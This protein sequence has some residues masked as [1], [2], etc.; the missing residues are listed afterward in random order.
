MALVEQYNINPTVIGTLSLCIVQ[1]THICMKLDK[2]KVYWRSRT[3]IGYLLQLI[4]NF[5]F[6]IIGTI[7]V[8]ENKWLLSVKC[9]GI[10]N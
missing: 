6:K 9:D 4:I 8:I 1:G 5:E 10:G 7:C 2:L 3:I